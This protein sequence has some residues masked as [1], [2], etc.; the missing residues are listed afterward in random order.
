MPIYEIKNPQPPG[1]PESPHQES[2]SPVNGVRPVIRIRHYT[3][4]RRR[5]GSWKR[6]PPAA[7][8]TAEEKKLGHQIAQT[9]EKL[10]KHQVPI[11]LVLIAADEGFFLEVYDCTDQQVC[12]AVRDLEID[13]AQLPF[14]LTKL[15]QEVGLMIDTIS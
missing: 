1:R 11:R 3:G 13:A 6:S 9:N 15:Q 5:P 2:P 8:P 7:A 14:F 10:E 12:R 4:R